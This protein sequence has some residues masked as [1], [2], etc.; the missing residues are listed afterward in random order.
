MFEHI[1]LRKTENDSQISAGRIAE[2]L[3][4][5]QRVHVFLDRPTLIRL[6]KQIGLD[7]LLTLIRRHEFSAVYCEEY[8]GTRTDSAGASQYHNFIEFRL[9]GNEKGVKFKSADESLS[10]TLRREGFSNKD[11][12]RFTKSF[13]NLV[14]LRKF[15][16]NHFLNGGIVKAAQLD[17]EDTDYSAKAIQKA[18]SVI[19]GGYE[20]GDNFR[21]EIIRSAL[22]NFIFT[23]I[24]FESINRRR[25]E[26]SP[27]LESITL[28]HL[29]TRLLDARADIALSSFYG[30]DFVTSDITSTIIQVRH[31]ELLRRT[32]LNTDA[33]QQ[34]TEVVLPDSPSL[35]EV[36]DSGSRSL[37]E[38]L[39]LLDQAQ[40]FKDWLGTVNPDEGLVRTYLRDMS[41]KGWIEKL[42]AKSLRYVLTLGLGATNPIIGA[43][44]GFVDNFLVEKVLSGWRPNHFISGKLSP[45]IQKS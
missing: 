7:L 1:V 10:Y 44:A 13:F 37:V 34:F 14:P 19:P 11:V 8:L 21:F 23:N 5:Y 4:Y 24:D 40:R 43:T 30:G 42:P 3:L 32:N 41:S 39:H 29:L 35:S 36:I 15:S 27:P 33:Y 26:E 31:A 25:L 18:I 45:F 16:G 2:A 22:G 6:A 12:K 17:L 9:D 38:F 28:A 20:I